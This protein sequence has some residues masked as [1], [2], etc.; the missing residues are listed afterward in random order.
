[1]SL[2]ECEL[3]CEVAE[4]QALIEQLQVC[5]NQQLYAVCCPLWPGFPLSRSPE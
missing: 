1:M 2:Q 3:Q 5:V 4:A